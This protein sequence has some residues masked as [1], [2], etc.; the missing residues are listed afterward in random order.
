LNLDEMQQRLDEQQ[1]NAENRAL[2]P[3]TT[4]FDGKL[5]DPQ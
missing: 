2:T 1:A 4:Y 5:L 3:A